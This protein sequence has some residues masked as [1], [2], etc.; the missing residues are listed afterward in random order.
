MPLSALASHHEINHICKKTF[1]R[2]FIIF[3]KKTHNL[4][5]LFFERIFYFLEAKIFISTKPDNSY[6]KQVLSDGFNM[7]AIGK[8]L[9]EEP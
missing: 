2:F 4:T 1:L 5:F 7:E 6:T 9:D 3:I 8:S